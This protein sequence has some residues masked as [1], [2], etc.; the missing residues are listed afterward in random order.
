[1][2]EVARDIAAG[3]ELVVAEFD[4]AEFMAALKDA[5]YYIQLFSAGY[6]R[7]DIEAAREA[8]VPI[9]NNGGSNSVAVAEHALLLMLAVSR[10]LVWQHENVAA[11]R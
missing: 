5:E 3:Y 6:D 4:S 7:L 2:L 1:V 11:R 10:R 9:S 8:R